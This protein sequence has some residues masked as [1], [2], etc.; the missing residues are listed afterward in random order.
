M[1][2]YPRRVREA[3]IK[4]IPCNAP[5]VRTV[6]GEYVCVECGESPLHERA[7]GATD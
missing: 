4:C 1:G 7:R 5:V 3:A 2:R 6:S